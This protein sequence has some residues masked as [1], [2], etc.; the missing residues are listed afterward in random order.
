MQQTT[1]VRRTP[2]MGTPKQTA[3][4]KPRGKNIKTTAQ[5]REEGEGLRKAG[6]VERAQALV[7]APKWL[8]SVSQHHSRLGPTWGRTGLGRLAGNRDQK[9]RDRARSGVQTDNRKDAWWLMDG[10]VVDSYGDSD[11]NSH[12]HSTTT[13]LYGSQW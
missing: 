5:Q 6:A 8:Q 1:L 12:Q 2:K 4:Q 9:Y 3:K 11:T 10:W 13:K 7:K